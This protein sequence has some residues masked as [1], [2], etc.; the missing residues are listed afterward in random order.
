MSMLKAILE[1]PV[2][3]APEQQ[4]SRLETLDSLRGI[5]ALTVMTII[6]LSFL[7][8]THTDNRMPHC[9]LN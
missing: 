8:Y 6:C 4:T 2:R 3:D 5:A 9:G 1:L 7:G